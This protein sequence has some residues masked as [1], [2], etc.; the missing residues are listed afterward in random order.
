MSKETQ[1]STNPF[2]YSDSNKRYHTFDYYLRTMFG[3]K[4][5][6]ISLD[7]GF[8][9]PNI[10]GRCST[11]GCIYCYDGSR[12]AVGT[13]LAD[14]YE[15][16]RAVMQSKWKCNSFIPYLQAHTNTYAPVEHLRRVYGEAASFERAVML[17]I[18]TRADCLEDEVVQ[19][20]EEV[21]ERIPIMVELGLQ[22]T[23]D[24][25]AVLI[26]RGH[27]FDDFCKGYE[28]LY[29]LRKKNNRV[30]IG[31]HLINGIP[32]ETEEDMLRSA[33]T[34][35]EM[36][37][38]MLKIHLMHVMKGTR[39]A[40]MYRMGEYEPMELSEYVRVI[41]NQ[42]ERISGEIAIGRVT[43]DGA[44]DCLI[45]PKWSIKKTVVANEIDKE[46]YRRG[47]YQGFACE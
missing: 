7:A 35:G 37:P 20:L 4:C 2:K 31:V 19:L 40:A 16:G 27:L 9:C 34:V 47:T 46:L 41:C 11:G 3:E 43:G 26:N 38:D 22:S 44:A 15:K 39:L 10:D 8:T 13:T 23:S 12:G 32:G 1:K 14:Q 17:G 33:V 42:L 21:S 5:A 29:S 24:K 28:K 30:K 45:A 25:S 36:K 6:K 18:A